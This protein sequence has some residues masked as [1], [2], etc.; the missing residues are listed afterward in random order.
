VNGSKYGV[1]VAL[2]LRSPGPILTA[3]NKRKQ[4]KLNSY[5]LEILP[6]KW[7]MIWMRAKVRHS[8]SASDQENGLGR[9]KSSTANPIPTKA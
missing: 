2:A 7:T 5:L 4:R 8:K 1:S 3:L 9:Q 6:K